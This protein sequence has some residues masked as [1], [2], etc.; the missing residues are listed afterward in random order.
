MPDLSQLAATATALA[1]EV[2]HLTETVAVNNAQIESLERRARRTESLITRTWVFLAA[3]VVLAAVVG[4]ITFRQFVSEDRLNQVITA[5][6]VA[7]QKGQCP[8]LALF[9]SSYNPDRRQPGTS[10]EE[11]EQAF[12]VIRSSYADLQCDAPGVAGGRATNPPVTP[13]PPTR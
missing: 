13:P 11:Y 3:L 9:I 12:G 8:L 7:R 2:E 10:R 6:H 5:E 4:V 1:A